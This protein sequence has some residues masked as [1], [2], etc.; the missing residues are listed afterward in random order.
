MYTTLK[1]IL[2]SVT[3]SAAIAAPSDAANPMIQK[4]MGAK[5][6]TFT[7]ESDAV[8]AFK[9]RLEAK[10]VPAL[11]K[12]LGLNAEAAAKSDDFGERLDELAKAAGERL[13]IVDRDADHKEIDLG[14]EVWP[15]PFPLEKTAQ[16]WQFN[17]AQGLQEVIDRRIGE[18]ENEAISTS[19]LF[20]VAQALY[21]SEDRDN[22]GVLEFAQKLVSTP[23]THDG[24]YWSDEGGDISPAGNFANPAK[25]EGA[26]A[27]DHGYF[28]YRF[29]ILKSQGSNVAGGQYSFVINGNMIAGFAMIARPAIY[30]QTGIMT[31]LVS[32]H[33]TVYQKDLGPDTAALAD[34]IMSFNPN[35]SWSIVQ[36]D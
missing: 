33:G 3:V 25:V 5:A 4:F 34:K 12:L 32:H 2:V 22:D 27:S 19:R 30:G 20:I 6:E 21:A 17:T 36:D 7:S 28:G 13:T 15:F 35:K 23:G 31:F 1:L 24:L 8:D 26:A 29:R 10:D 18:N 16:G 9:S 11:S 14:D